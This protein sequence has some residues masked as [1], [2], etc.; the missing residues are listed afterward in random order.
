V[1][2]VTAESTEDILK[3]T[4]LD[5]YRL[6]LKTN[7]SL[8][9][10]EVQRALNLSSPSVAQYHLSKL[11]QAGLVKREVGNYIVNRVLL[12]SCVKINRFLIPRYLF[13]TVFCAVI[14][15]L[16]LSLLQP[17]VV[18]SEYLF[19]TLAT[20]IFLGIFCFETIRARLKGNL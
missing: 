9:I 17:D 2:K 7:K 6:M 8:G 19:F 15:V 20:A 4:T 5:I 13:Y 10:R 18:S 16:E 1:K 12:D 11:E 3:G 14:L